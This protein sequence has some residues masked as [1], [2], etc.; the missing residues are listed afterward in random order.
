MVAGFLVLVSALF[1]SSFP[2]FRARAQLIVLSLTGQPRTTFLHNHQLSFC[3]ILVLCNLG[4]ELTNTV[5]SPLAIY[6]FVSKRTEKN[7][8]PRYVFHLVIFVFFVVFIFFDKGKK[9]L[10]SYD[11]YH[12]STTLFS[13]PS[14]SHSFWECFE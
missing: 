12:Y 9:A 2:S 3:S 10:N 7:A 8:S 13:S 4:S 6:G 11:T 14:L 5:A 1:Y